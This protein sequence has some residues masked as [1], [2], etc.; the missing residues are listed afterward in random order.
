MNIAKQIPT[1]LLA[2]AFLVFGLNYFLQF[3]PIPA[4]ENPD[5]NSAKYMGLMMNSGY[6]KFVKV[7]EVV[8]AV[9]LFIPRTRALGLCVIVP[10]VI[11]IF[12]F[13]AFIDGSPTDAIVWIVLSALAIFFNK[14]KFSSLLA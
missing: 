10:I 9:L 1:Y 4:P 13:H 11:N 7:L 3:F 14:E 8:G 5:S 12:A 2:L 6:M